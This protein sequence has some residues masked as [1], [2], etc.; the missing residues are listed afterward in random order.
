MFQTI[1]GSSLYL[2][3]LSAVQQ[4]LVIGANITDKGIFPGNM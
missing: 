3:L 2:S 1:K 4:I